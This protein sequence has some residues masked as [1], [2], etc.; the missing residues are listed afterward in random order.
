[1]IKHKN[2]KDMYIGS[3]CNYEQ[4]MKSHKSGSHIFRISENWNDYECSIL[5]EYEDVT[6]K[7]LWNLEGGFIK[8]YKPNLNTQMAGSGFYAHRDRDR[9]VEKINSTAFTKI[10]EDIY[11]CKCGGVV[12][13]KSRRGHTETEKHR[14]W[15]VDI[16][17]KIHGMDFYKSTKIKNQKRRIV[18]KIKK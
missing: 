1:M 14:K 17:Q 18:F 3:T 13:F 12:K 7:E 16:Y 5:G 9:A 15:L 8:Y 11:A 4:R 6:P 10:E 2:G